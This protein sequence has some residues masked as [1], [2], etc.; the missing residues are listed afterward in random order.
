MSMSPNLTPG[1][2][3]TDGLEAD[4]DDPIDLDDSSSLHYYDEQR[5]SL[6]LIN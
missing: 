2:K 6:S 3:R 1:S 5:G 4:G